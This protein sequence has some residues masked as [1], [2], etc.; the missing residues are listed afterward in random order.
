MPT[1]VVVCATTTLKHD[2][3][4]RFACI[5][6]ISNI[7]HFFLHVRITCAARA[8]Y[9]QTRI[10]YCER[11]I[12]I[13]IEAIPGRFPMTS[14]YRFDVISLCCRIVHLADR[15]SLLSSWH[16]RE[17]GVLGGCSPRDVIMTSCVTS[18]RCWPVLASFICLREN[19]LAK[20]C[21]AAYEQWY[22]VIMAMISDILITESLE[23]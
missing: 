16:H 8:V 21:E 14:Y 5:L 6:P 22:A 17:R 10:N 18:Q 11:W 20:L 3:L 7:A 9:K 2:Q 13:C 15:V 4:H 12:V 1:I 19:N 23:Q